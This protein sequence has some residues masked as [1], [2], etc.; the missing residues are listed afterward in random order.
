MVSILS[1][2]YKVYEWKLM[3][4]VRNGP[5][6]NHVAIIMDGNRRFAKKLGMKPWDG[7]ELGANKL[8]EVLDW[9]L[10]LGIKVVTVYG[11]STENKGRSH[12]E[13]DQLMKIIERKFNEVCNHSKIHKKKVR[14]KAIGRIEELPEGVKKA[15]K[16]AEE[17]TKDYDNYF[18]N[19]AILYGGRGEIVDAV[20][21]ISNAVL[22]G[23]LAP[24]DIDEKVINKNLYTAGL[25]DPDLIIRTSGEERISGF[26]LWQAAY[27][28]FY[29]CDTYWPV[30]RKV[31]FLRALRT[32]QQ[33]ER[34]YG[35]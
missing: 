29:F 11:F 6:P 3:Q 17:A 15:I 9:C 2:I 14:I 18:L 28:E 23:E 31:D 12:P 35:L 7:H 20:K 32:Y 1:P 30:F 21:K 33:R 8:E 34:R 27:S 5:I 24:E 22:S 10:E 13:L 26:L 19:V 25:P 4:E 16:K